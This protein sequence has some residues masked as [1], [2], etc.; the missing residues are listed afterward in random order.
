MD[1]AEA[2]TDADFGVENDPCTDP[3]GLGSGLGS[4]TDLETVAGLASVVSQGLGAFAKIS[5]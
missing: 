5:W 1:A 4:V 2:E 3:F